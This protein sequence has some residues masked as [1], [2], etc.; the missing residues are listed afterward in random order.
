MNLKGNWDFISFKSSL[1]YTFLQD[2]NNQTMSLKQAHQKEAS[3]TYAHWYKESGSDLFLK[4]NFLSVQSEDR[5]KGG[6]VMSKSLHFDQ[7]Q[8]NKRTHIISLQ[9]NTLQENLGSCHSCGHTLYSPLFKPLLD[10]LERATSGGY[11]A[12]ISIP[13][14]HP[15]QDSLAR[16][17][18]SLCPKR[19]SQSVH[20]PVF[21]MCVYT[22]R[23]KG[24]T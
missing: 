9:S 16:G 20:W 8:R 18:C 22:C 5:K 17:L 10:V 2:S 23:L 11:S 12:N 13:S 24:S 15:T 19:L 21:L 1:D 3:H 14:I 4:S 7:M 6:A